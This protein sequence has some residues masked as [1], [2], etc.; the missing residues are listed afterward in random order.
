MVVA[1]P[2]SEPEGAHRGTNLLFAYHA[3][4]KPSL[5][6]R[7]AEIGFHLCCLRLVIA[8]ID[9]LQIQQLDGRETIGG[10]DKT[11]L[12]VGI[13][14]VEVGNECLQMQMVI[15]HHRVVFTLVEYPVVGLHLQGGYRQ[16]HH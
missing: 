10:I 6:V 12:R 3:V 13:R 11:T 5:G 9:I 8:I 15:F 7:L 1:T 2:L 14:A 4:G 16:H